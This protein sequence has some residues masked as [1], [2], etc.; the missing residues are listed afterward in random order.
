MET[1]RIFSDPC[2]HPFLQRFPFIFSSPLLSS[3]FSL[4]SSPLSSTPLSLL[5]SRFVLSPLIST[6]PSSVTLSLSLS[7]LHSTPLSSTLSSSPPFSHHNISNVVES[8]LFSS[9]LYYFPYRVRSTRT[10]RYHSAHGCTTRP[11]P[12]KNE[13]KVSFR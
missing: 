8:S 4:F 6:P 2:F 1:K 7:L 13:N 10:D 3:L 5:Y 12:L 9:L 11:C